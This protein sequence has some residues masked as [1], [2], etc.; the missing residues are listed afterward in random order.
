MTTNYEKHF[1]DPLRVAETLDAA[2]TCLKAFADAGDPDM[3]KGC[4]LLTAMGCDQS[5]E[6]WQKW[7]ES[8][9]GQ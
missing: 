4:P 6:R 3:C 1:G 5:P 7:L 8:D 9:A 2:N